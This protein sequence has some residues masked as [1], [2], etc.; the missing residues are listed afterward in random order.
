MNFK[1]KI[2][3]FA[4]LLEQADAILMGAGSGLSVDAGIN[5]FDSSSFAE[6]YPAMLQYGFST[7]AELMGLK[8]SF[9]PELFWG[10]Y[11][12]H[13]NNMRFCNSVQPVYQQ[14]LEL[15]S[16]KKEYFIITTNVDALFLRNGFA[17]ERLYSPQGDYGRI[18]CQTP[19]SDQTWPSEPVIRGLL[20]LVDPL[21][22]KLPEEFVPTCPNCGGHVF[23]NIRGNDRFVDAPYE[24]EHNAFVKWVQAHKKKQ[25]LLIDIGT[26]FNT[27]V[28]IRWP[29]EKITHDNPKSHLI[30]IN[31]DDPDVPAPITGRSISFSDR[32]INVISAVTASLCG[33]TI[34]SPNKHLHPMEATH[35][36]K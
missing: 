29:F 27:P 23:Y 6:R 8:Q 15:M 16:R 17:K 11:L 35:E 1:E 7:N 21:T 22:G 33:C 24:H 18:Q 4:R 30:R 32:A 19:C 10:Y 13:G 9:F 3:H 36:F 2:D 28:W 5:Y 26:G 25:L 20:P 31:R 34:S 14:L 12:N